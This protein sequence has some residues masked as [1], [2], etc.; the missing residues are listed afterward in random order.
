MEA[1]NAITANDVTKPALNRTF[2]PTRV[3]GTTLPVPIFVVSLPRPG[4]SSV[5]KHFNYG[6]VKAS[7]GWASLSSD[8][9]IRVGEIWADNLA[10]GR[11]VL[12]G[13]EKYHVWTVRDIVGN[14]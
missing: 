6:N 5:F 8:K 11:P 2:V 13:S 1:Q 4:T 3:H 10:S 12:E 7:Y 14:S 9:V